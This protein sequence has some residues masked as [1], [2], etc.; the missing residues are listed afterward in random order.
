MVCSG[1]LVLL[2][3]FS[4]MSGWF[5]HDCLLG[6]FTIYNST[7]RSIMILIRFGVL[8]FPGDV[9]GKWLVYRRPYPE[10]VKRFI[11]KTYPLFRFLLRSLLRSKAAIK[12]ATDPPMICTHCGV[13]NN[14]P[15]RTSTL[16]TLILDPGSVSGDKPVICFSSNPNTR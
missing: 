15:L 10:H 11:Q 2:F 6:S 8:V 14:N 9:N 16:V 3:G 1:T 4:E 7:L 5:L 13:S 12:R